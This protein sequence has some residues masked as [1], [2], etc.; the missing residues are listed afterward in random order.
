M[1]SMDI[2][3]DYEVKLNAL[4]CLKQAMESGLIT[5]IQYNVKQEE[6]LGVVNFPPLQTSDTNHQVAVIM[7]QMESDLERA[8]ARG[9][10]C[11]T[12][13]NRRVT[14]LKYARFSVLWDVITR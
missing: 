5:R 6:F 7:R 12:I 11:F 9:M 10:L 3:L 4:R 14:I 2:A 13:V 8:K 1:S